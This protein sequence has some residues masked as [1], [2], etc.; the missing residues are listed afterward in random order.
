M[1]EELDAVFEAALQKALNFL[2][3]RGFNR[4]LRQ[5][6]KSSVKQLFTG[7][8]LLAVLPTGFGKSLIFQLLALVNDDHVGLVIC[9]LKSI[10][11]DQIKEAS[12]MGISA[13]SLS[14]CL[15]T[16]IVSG[17]YT[18]C[19]L[20]LLKKHSP[21]VSSRPSKEKAT[22]FATISL[23]LWWMSHTPLR[24]GLEKGK[25]LENDLFIYCEFTKNCS[26]MLSLR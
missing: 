1:P 10:V 14:D 17:N 3:E 18:V 21:K 5:E 15:Q 9:P 2:S 7:R 25:Q 13:G 20:L 8:D 26:L 19:F 12:S 4:E 11:N 23:L 24:L 22:R 6:Q 16:D